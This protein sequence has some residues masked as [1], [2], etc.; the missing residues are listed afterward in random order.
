MDNLKVFKKNSN[1]V[2]RSI[3]DETML[4][5]IYRTS[6]DINCI[7]TFN[8]AAGRIWQLI[9]GKRTIG[10]IKKKLLEEFDVTEKAMDKKLH[11]FLKDLNSI[12]AIQPVK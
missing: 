9:D 6:K 3:E 10:S 2:S 5:P 1:F 8:D 4:L 7:Y 12:K 11:D